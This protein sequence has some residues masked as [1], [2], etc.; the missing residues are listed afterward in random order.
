MR[1]TWKIN[2]QIITNLV[3]VFKQQG[4]ALLEA[5]GLANGVM[6]NN[7]VRQASM[8][9]ILDAFDFYIVIFVL[10]LP[11]V[12]LLKKKKSGDAGGH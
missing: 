1:N 8:Q 9:A 4:L 10:I 3:K 11:L 7:I 12:F 5:T 2:L 6:W